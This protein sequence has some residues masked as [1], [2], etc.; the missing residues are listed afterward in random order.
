VAGADAAISMVGSGSAAAMLA[1]R[2]L[3]AGNGVAHRFID[4]DAD[5]LG[6]L[7]TPGWAAG[8]RWRCSPPAA[9]ARVG[10][11]RAG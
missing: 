1:A 4:T 11:P 5:P 6:R 9:G 8:G 10:G 7:L 2:A 3:L